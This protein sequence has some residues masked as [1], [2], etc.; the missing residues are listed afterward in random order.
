[1]RSRIDTTRLLESAGADRDAPEGTQAHALAALSGAVENL[2][3]EAGR[4]C[5]GTGDLSDL[6]IALQRLEA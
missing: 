5:A 1:M 6:R 3:A 2:V 4:C